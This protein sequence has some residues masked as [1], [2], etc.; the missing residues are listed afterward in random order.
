MH[1]WMHIHNHAYI[2]TD[3]YSY[4]AEKP[5][6]INVIAT[7]MQ[8]YKATWL[9]TYNSLEF[10]F[11]LIPLLYRLD[12]INMLRCTHAWFQNSST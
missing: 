3:S 12:S 7:C 5:N 11:P 2:A 1:A 10:V 9:A 6:H 8:A 4:Y